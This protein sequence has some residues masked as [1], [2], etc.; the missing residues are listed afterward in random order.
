MA[1]K[2]NAANSN[3]R[4]H[5]HHATVSGDWDRGSR[6][7][8]AEGWSAMDGSRCDKAAPNAFE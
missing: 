5:S 6:D 8:L 1:A 7:L 3:L 2:D 4:A